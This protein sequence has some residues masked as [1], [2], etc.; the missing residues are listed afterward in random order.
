MGGAT[1]PEYISSMRLRTY[2]L[3][4]KFRRDGSS[5]AHVTAGRD[6]TFMEGLILALLTFAAAMILIGRALNLPWLALVGESIWGLF[7]AIG[8]LVFVAVWV[9]SGYE[10]LRRRQE[11]SER[12]NGKDD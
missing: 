4:V 5:I 11:R 12:S 8:I 1:H 7:M 10:H 3:A 2:S 9:A 6:L